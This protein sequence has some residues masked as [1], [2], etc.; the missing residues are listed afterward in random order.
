M[1]NDDESGADRREW[2]ASTLERVSWID[3]IIL[4]SGALMINQFISALDRGLYGAD[5]Y[6]STVRGW[7]QG[8]N[9]PGVWRDIL[10]FIADN[11]AVFA[12]VTAVV[13]AALG[14]ASLLLVAR[15]IA[16]FLSGLFLLILWLSTLNIS[17]VWG[18][19]YL[20]PAG[21][22]L[23]AGVVTLPQLVSDKSLRDR[24]LGPAF[25]G[26][27]TMAW[28]V[29]VAVVAAAAL[30][31]CVDLTHD[32]GSAFRTNAVETAIAVGVV[33]MAMAVLDRA[34]GPSEV[35]A[36]LEAEQASVGAT[37]GGRR[38]PTVI[39]GV[40]WWD[41]MLLFIGSM[42][43]IQVMADLATGWYNSAGYSAIVDQYAE[44]S[45]AASWWKDGLTFVTDHPSLFWPLQAV[46]EVAIAITL[47]ALVL[48]AP[49]VILTCGF[50]F[51]LMYSEFD[52]SSDGS[53]SASAPRT[54][55]WEMLFLVATCVVIAGAVLPAALRSR[56]WRAFV[57]GPRFYPRW[58]MPKRLGF[59]VGG[60]LVVLAV[61]LATKFFHGPWV[62]TSVRGALFF[63]G[64]LVLLAFVERFRTDELPQPSNGML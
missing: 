27:L 3:I 52:V 7:Q 45:G 33:L 28:R 29:V 46:F 54:W 10:G 23:I 58:P 26:K 61:G 30:G 60:A 8:T 15:G 38:W 41:V 1:T 34:R 14:L 19:E 32:G 4:L 21:F 44:T 37:F 57:F 22:S 53:L 50:F 31:Y 62:Q 20:F 16:A 11:S 49:T 5:G 51:T 43:C 9:A 39:A 12:P 56:S 13:V 36:T 2:L 48:R 47:T 40:P 24:L 55:I 6:E 64:G 63:L 35:A 59:A 18:Y 42:M 17:G 25:Y